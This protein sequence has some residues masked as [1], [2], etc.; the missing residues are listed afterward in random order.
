MKKTEAPIIIEQLY[1]MSIEKVWDAIT[2]VDL[3]SQWFFENIPSFKAELGFKTQFN[4]NSNERNFLY[5]WEVTEVIPLKKIAYNW[6]Y[7]DYPG[8]SFVEFELFEQDDG[9]KLRLTHHVLEDFPDDIA[10]FKRESGI[11]GSQYFIKKNLKE[12]LEKY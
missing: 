4:V 12:F 5:I 7:K 9:T 6:K 11:A 10:E 3:M 8:D 2:N 1:N